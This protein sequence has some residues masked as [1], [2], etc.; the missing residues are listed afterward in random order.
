MSR[1][2]YYEILGV[3]K[4]ATL[5]EIKKAYYRLVKS[6][7]PDGQSRRNLSKEDEARFISITEAYQLLRDPNKRRVYDR[8]MKM[9]Q[10]GSSDDYAS[11]SPAAINRNAEI[12]FKNAVFRYK[13]GEIKQALNL[14]EAALHIDKDNPKY[15]SYYGLC[16]SCNA[17]TIHKAR[18]YCEKAIEMEF[19]QPSYYTNLGIVYYNARLYTRAKRQLEFALKWDPDNTRALE[20]ME[21]IKKIEKRKSSGLFDIIKGLFNKK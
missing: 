6:L 17:S 4:D 9:D 11:R 20:Y 13:N 5:V 16:L 15:L 7:H 1:K 2:N 10:E 19:Y 3:R 21:K 8:E 12:Y 18:E 14:F